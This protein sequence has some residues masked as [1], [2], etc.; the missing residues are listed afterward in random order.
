MSKK[1][2]KPATEL[3]KDLLQE[4]SSMKQ[5]LRTSTRSEAT[6]KSMGSV[7]PPRPPITPTI[8]PT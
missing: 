4:K 1:E 8:P 7:K 3:I 2:I 6:P 5:D